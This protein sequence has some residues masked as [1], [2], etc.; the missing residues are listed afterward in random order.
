MLCQVP[1][2][3]P[4]TDRLVFIPDAPLKLD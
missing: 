2:Q 4:T 1:A 3:P